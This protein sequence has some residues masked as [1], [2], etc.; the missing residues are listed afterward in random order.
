MNIL[1]IIGI[2]LTILVISIFIKK[3][4]PEFFVIFIICAVCFLFFFIIPCIKELLQEFQ[5]AINIYNISN[6]FQTTIIK[7][8][9]ISIVSQFASDICKDSGNTSIADSISIFG[10]ISILI[11]SI[12]IFKELIHLVINLLKESSI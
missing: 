12:P 2:S 5:K 3:Y 9:G 10:R 7:I 11:S 1:S 6:K 4:S 8:I